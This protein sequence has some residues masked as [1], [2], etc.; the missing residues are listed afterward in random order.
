MQDYQPTL[1]DTQPRPPVTPPTPYPDEPEGYDDAPP[2]AGPGCFTWGCISLI[3]MG[4]SIL[5]VALAGFAGWTSG[6]REAT[7]RAAG[8]TQAAISDQLNR[9]PND[10][11]SGN[12]QMADM[13]IRYLAAL[14]PGVPGVN[15]LAA[16]ATAAYLT[17]QP[18]PTPTPS[19]TGTPAPTEA[20]ATPEATDEPIA[21]ASNSGYD[22]AALLGEARSDIE[23]GQYADAYET[24][25]VIT[26]LDENYES[27]TVRGLLSEALNGQARLLFNANRPAQAIIWATRA[28]DLG[29]LQGDLSFELFAAQ[30]YLNARAAIGIN[31]QRAIQALSEVYNL[32]QGRYYEEVRGLLYDQYVRLGDALAQDPNQGACPAV[33]QYQNALNIINDPGTAAKRGNAETLCSQAT[34]VG[35]GG[36]PETPGAPGVAPTFAPVGQPG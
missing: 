34:P 23:A 14:T 26:A 15:E 11:V 22:L 2:S 32:G 6:Q 36:T 1:D 4:F 28:E 21:P 17:R 31:P 24:L 7:T 25:D 29:V 16:T 30:N 35:G 3:G 10:I 27:A 19:P 12:L 13:R 8:A 9:I 20:A 5:I 33:Q 18:T